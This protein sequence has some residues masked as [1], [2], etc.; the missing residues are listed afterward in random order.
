MSKCQSLSRS[1]KVRPCFN[2]I[3]TELSSHEVLRVWMFSEFP[4]FFFP[5]F[6]KGTFSFQWKGSIMLLNAIHAYSSGP[7]GSHSVTL[8]SVLLKFQKVLSSINHVPVTDDCIEHFAMMAIP[9]W[10]GWPE[11]DNLT[12]KSWSPVT[13]KD[14]PRCTTAF[15]VHRA[16]PCVCS[17]T[18]SAKNVYLV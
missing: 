16:S 8:D 10:S 13:V 1:A 3:V 2:S 18:M 11:H 6:F 17:T 12:V 9:G 5:V 4:V 7:K 14:D 15:S